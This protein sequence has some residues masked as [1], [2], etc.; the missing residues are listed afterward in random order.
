ML[1]SQT[2]RQHMNSSSPSKLGSSGSHLRLTEISSCCSYPVL[3][4]WKLWQRS[5]ADFF[6]HTGHAGNIRHCA[7]FLSLLC[8]RASPS[9]S[10]KTYAT[11]F[12]FCTDFVELTSSP[13][14]SRFT[15]P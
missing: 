5:V 9:V 12:L 10:T 3:A 7:G 13:A 4:L 15:S 1:L 2:A 8:Q 6:S 11:V 14:A